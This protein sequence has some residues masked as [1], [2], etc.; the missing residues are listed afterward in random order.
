MESILKFLQMG[1]YA[2]YVWP[3]FILT[4]A[5]LVAMLV[6]SMRF[7][8]K[9]ENILKSLQGDDKETDGEA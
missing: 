6:S 2:A 7:M 5:V 8:K 1:G 3:C 4:A 9:S